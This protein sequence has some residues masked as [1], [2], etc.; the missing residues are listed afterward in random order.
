MD[1]LDDNNLDKNTIIL[2]MSDNGGLSAVARGGQRHTHNLPLSSGKG[3][4]REGGIREPML[5]KWSGEVEEGSISEEPLI[6]E[7]FYPTILE[8]AGISMVDVRQK[9]DGVS[10]VP[11]LRSNIA[12]RK[13]QPLVWHYPN[14]WGPSGPGIGA[15]S[16][17][18]IG[19]FK[20]IYYHK[21]E[22]FE[23]FDLNNDIGETTNLSEQKPEQR[24]ALAKALGK[25]LRERMAQM[26]THK[27]SGKQVRWPDEVL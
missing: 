26:P 25:L 12:H 16:A 17:I 23:L 1:Y 10:F 27:T 15:A 5:V 11:T 24:D 21:S 2:F 9:V 7:D 8:M 22:S 20:L 14:E 3:S 18:R 13:D 19:N 4:I 6:I